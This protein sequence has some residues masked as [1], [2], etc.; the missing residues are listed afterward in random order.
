MF[1]KVILGW[2]CFQ[3]FVNFKAYLAYL[4]TL[5]LQYFLS[6][7]FLGHESFQPYAHAR[8]HSPDL[9]LNSLL[10][11]WFISVTHNGVC[12]FACGLVRIKKKIEVL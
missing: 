10:K 4:G 7:Q 9:L 12:H 5:M 6:F 2:S 11:A 8:S 3:A 1:N